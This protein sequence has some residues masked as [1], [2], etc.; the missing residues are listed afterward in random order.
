LSKEK[1]SYP[2]DPSSDFGRVHYPGKKMFYGSYL[3]EEL[4]SDEI[5][6]AYLT[7]AYEISPILRDRN[8][9]NEIKI[10][11]GMWVVNKSIKLSVIPIHQKFENRT[12]LAKKL[13]SGFKKAQQYYPE[14]SN[15]TILWSNFISEE[16]AKNIDESNSSEYIISAT[17]AEFLLNKGYDGIIYPAMK[18]DGRGFNLAL[19]KEVVDSSLE[20]KIVA[21]A[22][23]YKDGLPAV[24]DW[25]RRCVVEDPNSF[26]F[27]EDP[28]KLGKEVC[29]KTIN[30]IKAKDASIQS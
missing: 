2:P 16:F 4:T 25:E 30:E 27:I 24:M 15:T 19:T 7:N 17:Y 22:R 5:K 9:K 23:I 10:T 8:S 6:L 20:L 12:A 18:V 28:E 21:E 3:P 1:I 13:S 11:I 29:L 26:I 14:Y